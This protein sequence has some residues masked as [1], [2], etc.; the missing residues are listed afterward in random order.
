VRL[1]FEAINGRI[2]CTRFEMWMPDTDEGRPVTASALRKVNIGT[3]IDGVVP[4]A[5]REAATEHPLFAAIAETF[6]TAARPKG[7]PPQYDLKHWKKV[8][9]IYRKAGGRKPTQAVADA[10]N[11]SRSTAVGWVRRCRELGV[12]GPTEERRPGERAQPAKKG[13]KR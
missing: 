3:L 9:A 11:V 2:E 7:R 13:K 1:N 5:V 12:L 4:D 10:E 6:P 8:A